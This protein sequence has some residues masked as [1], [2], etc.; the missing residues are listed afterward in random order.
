MGATTL[1]STSHPTS[2][3]SSVSRV[4][5][6]A[7]IVLL[8]TACIVATSL[9]LLPKP[10]RRGSGVHC[11]PSNQR[12]AIGSNQTA[13]LTQRDRCDRYRRPGHLD[14]YIWLPYNLHFPLF[15]VSP[16][17][18]HESS[19]T[20]ALTLE[21]PAS[22]N[23]IPNHLGRLA[24]SNTLGLPAHLR[25]KIILLVGDSQDRNAVLRICELTQGTLSLFKLNGS[26]IHDWSVKHSGDPRVCVN[27]DNYGNALVW[28][29]F[30]HLGVQ[31]DPAKP[32]VG[33]VDHL[34]PGYPHDSAG[35]IAWLPYLLAGAAHVFPE[36]CDAAGVPCPEPYRT[37]PAKFPPPPPPPP[38]PSEQPASSSISPNTTT[39]PAAANNTSSPQ[40]QQIPPATPSPTA[41][42]VATPL[43]ST[44][45]TAPAPSDPATAAAAAASSRLR[46]RESVAYNTQDPSL[47]PATPPSWYPR[48]DLIVAQ[49]SFWDVHQWNLLH[50]KPRGIPH[51]TLLDE[52]PDLLVGWPE[53][54]ERNLVRPLVEVVARRGGERARP[55]A[56]V[57]RTTP[58]TRVWAHFAPHV[59][60]KMN[61]LLLEVSA[62]LAVASLLLPSSSSSSASSLK[63]A[64]DGVVFRGV[65]DWARVVRGEE[66]LTDDGFHQGERSG[67]VLGEMILTEMEQMA[68]E[69]RP[70]WRP[71]SC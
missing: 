49:S 26:R 1:P 35:R 53:D 30:F 62:R 58:L 67:H 44:S 52:R 17:S 18:I 28:I 47:H 63:S 13:Q 4:I 27:R 56:M 14:G 37:Y 38:P 34:D 61:E 66:T 55:P 22:S 71:G 6:I 48:P 45:N 7:V 57:M 15:S 21:Q 31:R 50:A 60:A 23:T 33:W 8:V 43:N 42:V 12:K 36:I 69:E 24:A 19:S 70:D 32:F 2:T 40:P 25:N 10:H 29:T 5:R 16:H 9:V 39:Q 46:R 68:R 51:E 41:P 59:V 64:S 65:L 54:L 20:S 3:P 11:P